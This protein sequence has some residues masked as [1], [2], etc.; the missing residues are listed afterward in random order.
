MY[1]PSFR[2]GIDNLICGSDV[3]RRCV[4]ASGKRL[5]GAA[6]PRAN[7]EEPAAYAGKRRSEPV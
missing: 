3:A 6:A 5:N 4:T 2:I 1:E 7:S